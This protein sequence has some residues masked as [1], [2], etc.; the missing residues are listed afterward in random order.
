MTSG[1]KKTSRPDIAE[2][3]RASRVMGL[4]TIAVAIITFVAIIV[5]FSSLEDTRG[6]AA[7][8][9]SFDDHSDLALAGTGLRILSLLL[10]IVVARFLFS[11]LRRREPATPS[12]IGQLGIVA[13]VLVALM[14]VLGYLALRGV[15]DDFLDLPA[16]A[17]T[18]DRAEDLSDDDSLQRIGNIGGIIGA[19]LFAAWIASISVAAMAVGLMPRF[20]AYFGY[21]VAALTVLAPLVAPAL[22]MGWIG[23]LALLLLDRWP[24]G[25]PPSWDSGKVEPLTY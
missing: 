4:V 6:R 13:P 15:V 22:F 8:L 2:E 5:Q 14:A 10:L 25:R 11:A 3:Q 1:K 19:L 23:S 18:N 21:G 24:G 7:E 17:Q 20:L 16:Q 12:Y 9:R